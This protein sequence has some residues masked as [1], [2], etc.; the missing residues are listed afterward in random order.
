[1][2][3]YKMWIDGKWVD[4]DS[5]KTFRTYNPA[6][7]EVVAEVPLAGP[8]DVDKAVAA[9]RRAFPAWSRRTQAER[10]EIV[11]K[12]AAAVREH[13]AEI[14]R[15]EVLEHGAPLD[16]A[17]F[18]MKFAAENIEMAASGART[19]MGH[20][21]PP[22]MSMG[23]GPGDPPNAIAFMK[24]EPIGVCALITPW[25]V[26]SLLISSK[27]SPC[28]ANGNTCVLK[29]PSV[30]SGIGLKWAEIFASIDDLPPG[31]INVITG[32]G[33]TIGDQLS[34]HPGVDMIS[35]TGSSEVGK[36]II[37][38]SSQT[39]KK[40]CMELGGKNPAIVLEDADVVA[41][42]E[43]LCQITFMNVGQN[44]A[45]PSRFYVHEKIYDKFVEAYVA[46]A[47][48]IKVGDPCD[49]ST[50]MGPVANKEQRLTIERYIQSAI[51]EGATLVLGGKRPTEPPLDKGYFVM[52]TVFT[53]VTQNMK[54]AR[55][56][57]FG[58]VVGFLRFSSD[59][60]V[61]EAANDSVFGLCASVWTRDVARG[62]K[63][64]EEVHA[65]T[66]WVNQHMNLVAETP[67]GG[68]KESGLGKEGGVIG[69]D[70]FTQLKLVYVKHP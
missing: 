54:I 20:V 4:A 5:G 7:E 9:A 11:A 17:P 62:L 42:A 33:S 31:V 47:K 59:E 3:T 66:F 32:P 56:E 14:A 41:V 19:A 16:F 18:M 49:R 61:I 46:A 13:S 36:A 34:S 40:T 64:A 38:A 24:R 53:N 67:W 35:F 45:Q 55:E 68:F 29:P 63:F 23:Q 70:E 57:V 8:S 2:E 65:G 48:R 26:P 51:D 15:L 50:T 10:S 22:A 60:E 1:M 25:N 69:V 27:I 28:I 39:V 58:P 30:N 21:L 52:P 43:E 37:A 44:C 12:I 6:T